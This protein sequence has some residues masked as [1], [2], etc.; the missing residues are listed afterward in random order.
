MRKN[1]PR[2]KKAGISGGK[3]G[4]KW[5]KGG[6]G[7]FITAAA[8]S[9]VDSTKSRSQMDSPTAYSG[10]LLQAPPAK[11]FLSFTNYLGLD[12]YDANVDC[13]VLVISI[14]EKLCPGVC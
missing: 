6:R 14:N 3:I 9:G 13:Q 12:M 2:R 8:N 5:R 7:Y 1:Y 11:E 4:G 10:A